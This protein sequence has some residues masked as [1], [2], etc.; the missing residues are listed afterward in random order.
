MYAYAD[1]L[2][3]AVWGALA[4]LFAGCFV[5]WAANQWIL[6]RRESDTE[7]PHRFKVPRLSVQVRLIWPEEAANDSYDASNAA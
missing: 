2:G 1:G 6:W 5:F 7:H 4:L 3:L